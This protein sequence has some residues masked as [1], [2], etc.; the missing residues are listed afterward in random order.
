MAQEKSKQIFFVQPK[1]HQFKFAE[2][3]KMMP[4]DLLWLITFFEQC[5]AANKVP[6]FLRRSP[7]TR[8][9]QKSKIWLIFLTHAAV[10]QATGSI[11]T[12]SATII[13]AADA[14]DLTL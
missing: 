9:S 11:I 10:I 3:N 5:Q 7:R 1:A 14:I 6:A 12:R 13:K 2:S 8:S 4:T